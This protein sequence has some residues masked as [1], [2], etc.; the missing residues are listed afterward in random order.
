M[1]SRRATHAR[2]GFASLVANTSARRRSFPNARANVTTAAPSS[3]SAGSLAAM[4]AS[5][6]SSASRNAGSP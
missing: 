1:A 6:G 4:A 2:T 5:R 3:A